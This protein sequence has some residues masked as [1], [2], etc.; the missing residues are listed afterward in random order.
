[1]PLVTHSNSATS[2][3]TAAYTPRTRV[4]SAMRHPMRVRGNW[5]CG[6]QHYLR[7]EGA[8][9]TTY[10]HGG[11]VVNN[12]L[13]DLRL[14]PLEQRNLIADDTRQWAYSTLRT[15]DVEAGTSMRRLRGHDLEP[16]VQVLLPLPGLGP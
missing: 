8:S 5:V 12:T 14:D 11:R 1:M 10:M 2:G 13:F 3:G 15:W 4:R 6:E 7:S 16:E 9:L